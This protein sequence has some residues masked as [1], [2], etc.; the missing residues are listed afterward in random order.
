MSR[1]MTLWDT[2]E[3]TSSPESPDGNSPSNSPVGLL[4]APCGRAPAR[5]KTSRKPVSAEA[6]V[7]SD[8][9]GP[10]CFGSSASANLSRSLASKLRQQL[11]SNGSME[12]RQTWKRRVTP[13]GRVYW[14]HTASAARTSDSGFIG[15]PTANAGMQNDTDEHWQERR[16]ECKAKH[17]QNGFELTLGMVSTLSGWM[18]SKL[19]SGGAADRPDRENGGLRK[20]EDQVVTAGWGTPSVRDAKD[21][22]S[23]GTAPENGLLGR[24]VWNSGFGTASVWFPVRTAKQDGLRWALNPEFSAWK[25]GF[26]VAW[27]SCGRR[28]MASRLRRSRKK[29]APGSCAGSETR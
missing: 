12:Y 26:P 11:G 16:A 20:L 28:A 25:M 13:L 6:L 27:I 24:M 3:F 7:V 29:A 10:K 8:T 4:T 23:F 22:S 18:T 2:S 9:S 21:S 1:Q 19:P 14:E 15:W 5:V 17:G